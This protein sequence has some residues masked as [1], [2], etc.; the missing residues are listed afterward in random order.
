MA[1]VNWIDIDDFKSNHIRRGKVWNGVP[2]MFRIS[3]LLLSSNS[4]AVD[5]I[6]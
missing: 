3:A 2:D 5:R 6:S 1:S 4:A